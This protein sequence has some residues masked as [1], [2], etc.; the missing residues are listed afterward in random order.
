[1]CNFLA[2][3][4]TVAIVDITIEFT[5]VL[6][7]DPGFVAAI[8][9]VAYFFTSTALAQGLSNLIWMPLILKYGRRPVYLAAFVLYFGVILWAGFTTNYGSELAARILL[10]FTSGAGECL[11]PLTI[12]DLFFLH[13]RGLY[14]A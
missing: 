6:P 8:G 11:A 3:G 2:A 4:A 13:E 9:R 14:M 10:G 5:G 7:T 1:M 12:A